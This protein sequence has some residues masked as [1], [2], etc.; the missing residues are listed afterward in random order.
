MRPSWGCGEE[1]GGGQISRKGRP[2]ADSCCAE[3]HLELG[4]LRLLLLGNVL[5]LDV[6]VELDTRGDLLE[7]V[8]Q[9]RARR[10]LSQRGA[11]RNDSQREATYDAA[12]VGHAQVARREVVPCLGVVLVD[13]GAPPE[14][15][16]GVLPGLLLDVRAPEDEPRAGKQ[17]VDGERG[18][19]EGDRELVVVARKV[20]AGER[21]RGAGRGVVG[22]WM[23]RKQGRG[24]AT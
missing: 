21:A 1:E 23:G 17:R 20:V 7:P 12:D 4:L 5:A 2:T 13:A 11:A 9:N 8:L 3:T 15:P 14:R 24:S 22:L 19:E 18:L 16:D 10:R 6:V